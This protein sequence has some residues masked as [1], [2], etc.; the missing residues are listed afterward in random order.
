MVLVDRKGQQV[1]LADKLKAHELGQLHLAFSV[2]I[3]RVNGQGEIGTFFKNGPALNIT[4]VGC[5]V[6]H[7]ARIPGQGASEEAA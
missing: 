5:G 1:G 2:M 4:A 6:T 3:G 7:V